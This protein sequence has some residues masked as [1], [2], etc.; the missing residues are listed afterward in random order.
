VLRQ[1]REGEIYNISGNRSLPNLEVVKKVLA[2]TGRGEHLIEYVKDRPGHDR[3]Y[4]LSSEKLMRELRWE[5]AD[6]FRNHLAMTIDW[7]GNNG[8]WVAR[9]RTGKYQR[10]YQRN[11]AD[12]AFTQ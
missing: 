12:R 6:G 1:G 5:P 8:A 11:D 10:Y 9:M 4:A 7:Y 2:L 3:R